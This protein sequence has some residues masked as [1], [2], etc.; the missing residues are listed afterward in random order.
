[1]CISTQNINF[2]TQFFLETYILDAHCTKNQ[3]QPLNCFLRYCKDFANMLFWVIRADLAMPTKF[4]CINLLAS[5]VSICI[6]KLNFIPSLFWDIAKISKTCYFGYFGHAWLWPVKL[7]YQPKEN[8]DVY[9]YARNHIYPFPLCWTITKYYKHV[10]F[11][12]LDM[13]GH[14]HLMQQH[15]LAGNSDFICKQ[16]NVN[17]LPQFFRDITL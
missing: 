1:M 3:L 14:A 4:N 5:L 15:Q 2:I 10:I 13:S 11:S 9:L 7:H 16:N 12:T 6:Q 17:W 8:F